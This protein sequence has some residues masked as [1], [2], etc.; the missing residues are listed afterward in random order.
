MVK[1][2]WIDKYKVF[3][4]RANNIATELNDDNLNTFIGEPKTICTESYLVIGAELNLDLNSAAN[5]C[6]YLTT[7][8][9]RFLHSLAKSSQDATSKTFRFVPTENFT[10][11]SDID[12]SLSVNEVDQQLYSKYNLTE[13]E[14]EFIEE[15]IKPM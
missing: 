9:A 13:E 4:P 3:T 10:T 7:K 8:F 15:S 5:L 1:K 2:E 14:I 11:E 12:W 6:K